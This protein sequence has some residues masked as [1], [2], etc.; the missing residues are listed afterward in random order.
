MAT[1]EVAL[2]VSTFER[3]AHLRRCLHSIAQQRDVDGKFEVVVTDDGSQDETLDIVREFAQTANFPLSWTTHPHTDFHLAR[4]RNEGVASSTAPYLIFVDGDCLLP[5]NFVKRHLAHRQ[6]QVVLVGNS[7]RF[8]CETSQRITDAV[9]ESGEY[10]RWGAFRERWRIATVRMKG[11]LY[12]ALHHPSKPKPLGGNLAIWRQDYERV[13]GYDEAF[14]GWGCE[15]DDLGWRLR[16][17]GLR[18]K[19]SLGWTLTYHLWHPKDPSAPQKWR[20]GMNVEKLRDATRQVVC[21]Q[22]LLKTGAVS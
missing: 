19:S 9:I 4:C 14:R 7:F 5:P 8:D 3:P 20:E 10:R 13:N 6:P 18:F 2:L 1:P 15:D 22:G 11:R 17:A 16:R 12:A 21:L